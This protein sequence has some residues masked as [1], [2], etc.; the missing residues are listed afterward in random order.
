MSLEQA[1]VYCSGQP[2]KDGQAWVPV[3]PEHLFM[4]GQGRARQV[5]WPGEG[6]EQARAHCSGEAGQ[7]DMMARREGEGMGGQGGTGD[8]SYDRSAGAL[9]MR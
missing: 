6:G 2:G 8:E 5:G 4:F 7:M 1:R 3:R 9:G